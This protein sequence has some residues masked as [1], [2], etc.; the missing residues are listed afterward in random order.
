MTNVPV[1]MILIVFLIIPGPGHYCSL[2]KNLKCTIYCKERDL[3][4]LA[5]KAQTVIKGTRASSTYPFFNLGARWEWVVRTT[6]LPLHP[7]E[8]LRYPLSMSLGEPRD[9]S[10]QVSGEHNNSCPARSSNPGQSSP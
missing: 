5:M 9:Q 1:Y 8:K 3:L 2:S 6:S 10:G 4:Q 7:R